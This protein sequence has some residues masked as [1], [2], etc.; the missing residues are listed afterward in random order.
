M[1]KRERGAAGRGARE[2]E[3]CVEEENDFA[4]RVPGGVNFFLAMT[5][6]GP[7]TESFSCGLCFCHCPQLI[8]PFSNHAHSRLSTSTHHKDAH[9]RARC[10]FC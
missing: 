6:T 3:A 7:F 8:S 2:K 9:A 5:N 1:E 4:V 10:R